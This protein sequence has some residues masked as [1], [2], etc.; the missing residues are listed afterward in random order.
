MENTLL[1][2]NGD[3]YTAKLYEWDT[4]S[5]V[6]GK[7]LGIPSV[8]KA[9]HG[10]SNDRITRSTLEDCIAY[11]N[12][13][14]KPFVVLAYSFVSREEV[15]SETAS[16]HLVAKY[17]PDNS[18]LLV[19]LDWL[20]QEKGQGLTTEEKNRFIDLNIN[21]QM[22][23]FYTSVYLMAN[24]LENIGI[25]YFI[26]SGADNSDYKE[27]NWDYLQTLQMYNKVT[28]NKNIADLHDLSIS[29]WA[30]KN[31]VPT[32]STGHLLSGKEH[33]LFGNYLYENYIKKLNWNK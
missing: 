18:G 1:Y 31:N 27:L 14:I 17:N 21:K 9:I 2:V 7:N 33:E 4:Y 10:S 28:N 24:T 26:F 20:L 19:T 11:L 29:G 3:S 22:T 13:G 16:K 12:Q 8:N 23:D 5:T 30:K 32:Q 15:W 25:D 6:L